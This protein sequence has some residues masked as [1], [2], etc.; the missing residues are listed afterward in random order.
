MLADDDPRL[1]PLWIGRR[2]PFYDLQ[3]AI[4]GIAGAYD[5]RDGRSDDPMTRVSLSVDD[6]YGRPITSTRRFPVAAFD[7]V[8]F[9]VQQLRDRR[10]AENRRFGWIDQ[11]DADRRAAVL[12]RWQ[13][14]GADMDE[15][16]AELRE[17]YEEAAR[18]TDQPRE[19]A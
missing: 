12:D 13:A 16:R 2:K 6:W 17:R 11:V 9:A 19:E 10:F 18:L 14:R 8:L 3:W 5:I 4:G 15:V 7:D 1:S